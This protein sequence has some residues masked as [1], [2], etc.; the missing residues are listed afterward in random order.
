MGSKGC[1]IG[2]AVMVAALALAGCGGRGSEPAGGAVGMP[3]PASVHCE[4]QGYTLEIRTASD[5]GQYGVCIFDD[6]TECEEWAYFRGECSPG[7]FET[8]PEP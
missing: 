3:N 6:G 2:L 5:G 1:W 8:A 4:E 7:Q